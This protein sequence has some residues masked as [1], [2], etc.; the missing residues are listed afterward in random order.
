MVVMDATEAKKL[1]AYN[2]SEIT[3]DFSADLEGAKITGDISAKF[4]EK[5]SNSSL[6][7]SFAPESEAAKTLSA[8]LLTELPDDKA[9]PNIYVQ[10]SG[11]D[12][13]GLGAFIDTSKIQD[14]WISISS[15]YLESIGS[16]LAEADGDKQEQL[17]AADVAELTR[18]ASSVS[19]DYLFNADKDK[20]VFEQK[21]YVGKETV[22]GVSVYHYKINYNV[23][24]SIAYCKALIS[25]ELSTKAFKKL[26]GVDDKA[27]AEQKK[28]ANK[29]CEKEV[30]KAL[31]DDKKF[32]DDLWIDA[33]YKLIYKL[34]MHDASN[35]KNYFDIGQRYKGGDELTFFGEI[36][37]TESKGDIDFT[38]VANT[39]TNTTK[40]SVTGEFESGKSKF[41][42]NMTAK[43]STGNV[44][45]VA[46][47]D[48]IPLQQLLDELSNDSQMTF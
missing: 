3:G 20:A 10:L 29:T 12:N 24:N 41:K 40:L 9:F 14:R 13:L 30:K 47:T 2:K 15:E 37:E 35:T 18:T 42:L 28:D 8:K 22:D 4:D 33:K 32:Q 46:P 6:N 11:L 34:R 31:K 27:I 23:N 25:A 45:V 38:L 16:P 19:R 48:A 26:S 5:N 7:V 1:E 44:N 17:T 21:D 39:K 43:P 36:V